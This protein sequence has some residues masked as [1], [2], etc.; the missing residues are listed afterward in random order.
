MAIIR[1]LWKVMRG[2]G[3]LALL[4]C[5]I[6]AVL[7]ASCLASLLSGHGSADRPGKLRLG[8]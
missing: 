1:G 3:L 6:T 8:A 7:M 2:M 5:L 4:A